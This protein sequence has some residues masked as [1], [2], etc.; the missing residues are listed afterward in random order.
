VF[1]WEE[2]E[3]KQGLERWTDGRRWSQSRLRN[4]FLYYDEKLPVTQEERDLK[5]ARR[6]EYAS[7]STTVKPVFR[8]SDRPTKPEGL[9]KQTFSILVRRDP[10]SSSYKKWH[11]VAYIAPP[12]QHLLP[13]PDQLDYLRLNIPVGVFQSSR[14]ATT[15]KGSENQ[16]AGTDI[17]TSDDDT[18]PRTSA[19]CR[20]SSDPVPYLAPFSP[21]ESVASGSRVTPKLRERS[22]S[23]VSYPYP[24]APMRRAR[25]QTGDMESQPSPT[26]STRSADGFRFSF[27]NV[28]P[29]LADPIAPT[30]GQPRTYQP[31]SPED[32]RALG[33]FHLKL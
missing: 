21:T 25:P 3:H 5:A 28:R 19:P 27:A 14:V 7:G 9:T 32:S 16:T 31:L 10:L 17:T 8:R 23:H 15:P 20:S 18:A 22:Y 29:A 30:I 6:A 11:I 4:E 26:A 13:S 1:V 33:A 2:G 12:Q 24:P